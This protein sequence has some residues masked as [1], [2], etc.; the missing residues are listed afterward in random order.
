MEDESCFTNY[1]S[2]PMKVHVSSY[3]K[4]EKINRGLGGILFKETKV[5][6]YIKDFCLGDDETVSRWKR[7]D[8]SNWK[9]FL[10]YD[11]KKPIGGATVATRTKDVDMLEERNDLAVLWD[12][13][14][15]DDYKRMGIGQSLFDMSIKWAKNEGM[16]QFK[17]ECQNNNVPAVNFYHKQG[18]VLCSF[19]EFAYY[20][21]EKYRDEIQLIWYINL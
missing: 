1:D 17:I 5:N 19:N 14:V 20:N 8:L 15:H 7:W 16:K 13:R 12:I 3:Y 6:P 11:N 9:F 4:I 10:A 2:I 18:A 21:D